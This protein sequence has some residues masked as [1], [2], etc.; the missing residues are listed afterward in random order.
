MSSREGEVA[1]L[2]N[3][4]AMPND[5]PAAQYLRHNDNKIVGYQHPQ[6]AECGVP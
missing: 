2:A 5:S 6:F 1:S 3:A 4:I